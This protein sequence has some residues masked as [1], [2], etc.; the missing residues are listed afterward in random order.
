MNSK[1]W[2]QTFNK[3]N[4]ENLYETHLRTEAHINNLKK[5]E[6]QWRNVNVDIR[7]SNWDK[8]IKSKKQLVDVGEENYITLDEPD[9]SE[10]LVSEGFSGTQKP[11]P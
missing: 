3:D 10:D 6:L 11:H 5:T 9:A 8:H 1:L 4:K 7:S 2:C